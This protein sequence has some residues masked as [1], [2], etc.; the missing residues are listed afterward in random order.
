RRDLARVAAG[1]RRVLDPTAFVEAELGGGVGEGFLQLGHRLRS[2][3]DQ[4]GGGGGERLVPGIELAGR[5]RS[6][7]DA[8][9][10]GVALGQR[11]A[12]A[13]AEL[14]AGRP[15]R[16]EEAV[17]MGSPFRR[18]ALHQREAIGGE[19][20]DGWTVAGQRRRFRGAAVEQVAA[21]L[22]AA[23]R[24][25]HVALDLVVVAQGRLGTGEGSAERDQLAPVGRPEG[26]AGER[27]VERLEQ[28]R[29][30]GAVG[31]Y[32]AGDAG[33]QLE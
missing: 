21:A 4:G 22:G 7:R 31:P 16:D 25:Q 13:L 30:A 23:D 24:R 33:P 28:V 6:R 5:S 3:G 9:D 15:A 18:R 8:G 2:G 17:E 11:L 19:D 14:G 20:R 26:A 27:E 1:P 29:L 10:E 32:E 12:E